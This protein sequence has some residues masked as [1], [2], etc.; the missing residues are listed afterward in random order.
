MSYGSISAGHGRGHRNEPAWCRSNCGERRDVKR[1]TPAR[2]GAE[3]PC[4]K[5]SP[6]CGVPAMPDPALHRPQIKMAQGAKPGRGQPGTGVPGRP[7]SGAPT[8]GVGLIYTAAPPTSTSIEDLAQLIRP[9]ERQSA[10]R[11]LRQAIGLQLRGRDGCGWRFPSPRRRG[12][13]LR[14]TMVALARR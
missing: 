1:P 14:G 6:S 11:K 5:H 10:P 9:K 12:L 3:A 7:R 2:V 8:P 13:D 4:G